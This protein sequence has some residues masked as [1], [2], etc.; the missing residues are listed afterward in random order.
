MNSHGDAV[1]SVT[2]IPVS[3]VNV[4]GAVSV[5]AAAHAARKTTG[6]LTA[7]ASRAP[8]LVYLAAAAPPVTKARPVSA[9]QPVHSASTMATKHTAN[10]PSTPPRAVSWKSGRVAACTRPPWRGRVRGG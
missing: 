6:G 2:M 9:V 8:R 3:A 7:S 1:A 4:V 10:S 5:S